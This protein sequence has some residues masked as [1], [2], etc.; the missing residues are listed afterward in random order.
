MMPRNPSHIPGARLNRP[1]PSLPPPFRLLPLVLAVVVLASLPWL[2]AWY[3]AGEAAPSAREL[4][5]SSLASAVAI[6][7]GVWVIVLLRR[8]RRTAA[9][10][11]ADLEALTLTDP[12]TGLGNRRAL[13]R[14]LVR[15][16]LRSR[17]FAHPLALL[18]MDV[19]DLKVVNDRFGHAAGDD[20]LRTV[21]VAIRASSRDGADSGYRVGGD[22]FV[23]IV[24]ADREGAERL[25]R[26]VVDTFQSGAAHPTG[27]SLGVVEWDGTMNAAELLNEADR[28]MYRNKHMART[29]ARERGAANR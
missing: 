11:L 1:E 26:R 4:W 27:L 29:A 6:A 14:E 19:D 12:L 17:R 24:V 25:A 18:Y 7:F 20:T 15:S 2:T 10:H 23:L 28:L 16:M 5:A 22:E 13:E 9:R 21:G 3:G 8:E